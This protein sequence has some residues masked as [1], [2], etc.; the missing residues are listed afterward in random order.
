M[1]VDTTA[2]T[3]E[4]ESSLY[5]LYQATVEAIWEMPD[6]LEKNILVDKE[7]NKMKGYDI[8]EKYSMNLNTVK[9]KI[10]KGRKILKEAVLAKNADLRDKI[11]DLF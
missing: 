3:K 2:E 6:S 4:K 11:K 10:R 5:K 8:A 7:L 1:L 9:T